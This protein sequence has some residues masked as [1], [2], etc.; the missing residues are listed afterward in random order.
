MS[1]G[2]LD[3][4]LL[5][6]G[7]LKKQRDSLRRDLAK[8]LAA[9]IETPLGDE[10][11]E[12]LG[13]YAIDAVLDQA[14]SNNEFLQSASERLGNLEKK[15]DEVKAEMGLLSLAGYRLKASMSNRALKLTL[16]FILVAGVAACG[17][18]FYAPAAPYVRS[19]AKLVG[20]KAMAGVNALAKWLA[21]Q[22][23]GL[24]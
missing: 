9:N 10:L 15:L 12:K 13:G 18:L 11:E 4:L 23:G 19:A 22:T 3:K 6:P 21:V 5:K 7:E 17:A 24:A 16:V 1:P 20:L 8:R 14:L 2:G